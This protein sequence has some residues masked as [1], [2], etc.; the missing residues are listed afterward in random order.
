MNANAESTASTGGRA[1][2]RLGAEPPTAAPRHSNRA[3]LYW[4]PWRT[5]TGRRR[6]H[7]TKRRACA[8][9]PRRGFR[10]RSPALGCGDRPQRFHHLHLPRFCPGT[11][12]RSWRLH[13]DAEGIRLLPDFQKAIGH[14]PLV[15]ETV[16]KAQ[17]ECDAD[18]TQHSSRM[19]GGEE[20][21][22][23]RLVIGD[24]Y[25]VFS[26]GRRAPD[27]SEILAVLRRWLGT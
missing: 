12:G 9:S 14:A 22:I 21:L 13:H 11:F 23:S 26:S 16:T 7:R 19:S 27:R 5:S 6:H 20:A 10:D 4:S 2:S 18:S 3:Q 24:L 1:R 25:A 8:S 17:A 15:D